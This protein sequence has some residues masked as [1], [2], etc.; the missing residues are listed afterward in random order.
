MSIPITRMKFSAWILFACLWVTVVYTPVCH[1]AWGGGWMHKIGALD[2]AGGNVVRLLPPLIIEERQVD[3]A[4][5]AIER[6]CSAYA[7]AA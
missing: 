3:E 5:Q 1:W 4:V 2:F 6:A 7:K